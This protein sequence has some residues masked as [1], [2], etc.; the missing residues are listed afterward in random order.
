M[1][2]AIVL[3]ALLL[4]LALP[5]SGFAQGANPFAPSTP[6]PAQSAPAP[7]P[8]PVPAPST[9]DDGADDG[10]TGTQQLLALLAAA[11]M[12]ALIAWFIVRDAHQSAPVADE[13]SESTVQA[14]ARVKGTA[15]RHARARQRSKA[16]RRQR[17]RNRAR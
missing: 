12:I 14:Q 7:D 4:A 13:E 17:K 1:R 5:A 16:A 10:L 9:I 3:L 8:E 2:G 11:A 6:S 15:Q